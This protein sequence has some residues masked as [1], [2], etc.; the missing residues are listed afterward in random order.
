M[1]VYPDANLIK[2]K[3][4]LL[5]LSQHQLSLKSELSGCAICRIESKKTKMIHILR[6]KQIAHAL[7]CN[8]HD[9]FFMPEK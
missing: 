1:F 3:R 2:K 4:E 8:I 9:I 7:H 5:G 6:A